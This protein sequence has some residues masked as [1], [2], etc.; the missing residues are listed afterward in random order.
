MLT[1]DG[2]YLTN[3]GKYLDVADIEAASYSYFHG[4][5]AGGSRPLLVNFGDL[6][7]VE[8]A[9]YSLTE[10]LE[11]PF[12]LETVGWAVFAE[13]VAAV[14]RVKWEAGLNNTGEIGGAVDRK[15]NLWPDFVLQQSGGVWYK[16]YISNWRTKFYI[17]VT[18]T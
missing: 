8:D 4:M 2:K 7:E 12:T 17:S 3:D 13:P 9:L 6:T 14:T 15:G 1:N 16:V 5:I 11:I 10:P 18:V